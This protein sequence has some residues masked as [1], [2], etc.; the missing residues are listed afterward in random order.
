[1]DQTPMRLDTSPYQRFLGIVFDRIGDGE[2]A[3][4]LPFREEFL[5]EDGSDWLHGGIIS[6]L[7][8]IAGDY[9]IMTKFNAGVPTIDLRID[10]LRPARSGDLVAT[11]RV[12]KTGRRVSVADVE[13]HDAEGQLVAIGRGL[14]ASPERKNDAPN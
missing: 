10:G 12:V 7:I 9:A 13:V 1:V 11:G 2:V 3:I 6:A 8:D 5:R 4:R 14:Y